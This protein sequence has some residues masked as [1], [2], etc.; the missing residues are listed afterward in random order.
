MVI[1][2]NNER[3]TKTENVKSIQHKNKRQGIADEI[4]SHFQVNHHSM[5]SDVLSTKN[6]VTD[7]SNSRVN[8]CIS[9]Q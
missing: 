9:L 1:K 8:R 3:S 7:I 5:L 4:V 6:M 2:I